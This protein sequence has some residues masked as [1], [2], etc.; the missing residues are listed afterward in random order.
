MLYWMHPL[1]Q[2]AATALSLYVL[3]LGWQRFTVLHLGR[4]GN[5]PWKRHVLLG[6]VALAAW[7]FGAAGGLAVAR[8]EWGVFFMTETH[9]TVGLV[10]VA[11][12]VFGYCS[13][14]RLDRVKKRRFWLPL[15][16]GA[17]NCLL[18]I[19]AFVQAWT[20]WAFL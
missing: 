11:L 19:L 14:R 15:L 9:A 13:G 1:W 2:G 6:S 5:F 4:K 20:G 8:L 10:F 3:F 7:C 18:V 12:A 17:N 16:H